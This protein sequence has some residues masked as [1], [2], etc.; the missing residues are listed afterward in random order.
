MYAGK[1][2]RDCWREISRQDLFKGAG[3]TGAAVL[4]TTAL[5]KN[6]FAAGSGGKS[7]GKGILLLPGEGMGLNA[8]G[9]DWRAPVIAG[10]IGG[11]IG[12][13]GWYVGA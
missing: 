9:I 13:T 6:L 10:D 2:K 3:V 8:L 7:L 11:F 5:G 4:L 1:K 12:L